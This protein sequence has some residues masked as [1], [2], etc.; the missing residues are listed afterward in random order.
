VHAGRANGQAER[1]ESERIEKRSVRQLAGGA[2]ETTPAAEENSAGPRR[3][4]AEI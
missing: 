4:L 2:R 1:A 3:K